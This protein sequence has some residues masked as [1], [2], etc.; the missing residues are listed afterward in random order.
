MHRLE[1]GIL[2]AVCACVYTQNNRNGRATRE[3]ISLE[4]L[5]IETPLST[6]FLQND[7][8][9]TQNCQKYGEKRPSNVMDF[10]ASDAD[11]V[12]AKIIDC[13]SLLPPQFI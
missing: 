2:H 7:N 9:L 10:N 6:F 3:M 8:K 4:I 13:Y 11:R 5:S 1:S 12:T